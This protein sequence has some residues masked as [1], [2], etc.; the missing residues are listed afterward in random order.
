MSRIPKPRQGRRRSLLTGE[1][2]NSL[3]FS[4][5]RR[6]LRLE[7][8]EDR[9]LL[10]TLWTWDQQAAIDYANSWYDGHNTAR[11]ADY[12]AVGGDCA[13]FVSQCLIAG[14][15]DLSSGIVDGYGSIINCDN[16]HSY[17]IGLAGSPV[18]VQSE[19]RTRDQVETLWFLP[20]DPAIFGRADDSWTHAVIAVTGDMHHYCTCASHSPNVIYS[21]S[22]FFTNYPLLTQC[23]YYDLTDH[24]EPSSTQFA[25]GDYL[26]ATAVVAMRT[27][28]CFGAIKVAALPSGIPPGS[29]VQVLNDAQNGRAYNGHYWWK[30]QYGSAVGWCAGDWFTIQTLTEDRFEP[31]DSFAAAADWG[32]LGD[33]SEDDL[34]IHAPNN[35][36]YYQFTA[37]STGTMNV[38]IDFTHSLGDLDLYFYDSSQT[39]LAKSIGITNHEHLSYSV[40]GGE[41]YYIKVVGYQGATNPLYRLVLSFEDTYHTWD[42]GGTNNLWTTPENWIGDDL[43]IPAESVVFPS[44]AAPRNSINDFPPGTAFQAIIFEGTGYHLQGNAPQL[45]AGIFDRSSGGANNLVDF[46]GITLAGPI[47]LQN[48]RSVGTLVV[49]SDIN[50]GAYTLTV[51]AVG[52]TRLE[53][54]ISG[55]GGLVKTGGDVLTI[56]GANAYTGNTIVQAGRLETIQIHS[57]EPT[58]TVEVQE[59]A[60]LEAEVIHSGA[61]I[62]RAGGKVTLRPVTSSV[63]ASPQSNQASAAADSHLPCSFPDPLEKPESRES[64]VE[65]QVQKTT[66]DPRSTT[67]DSPQ[68][69]IFNP[70]EEEEQGSSD[71]KRGQGVKGQKSRVDVRLQATTPD[72]Q[73]TNGTSQTLPAV[74]DAVFL[75]AAQEQWLANVPWIDLGEPFPQRQKSQISLGVQRALDAVGEDDFFTQASARRIKVLT[76]RMKVAD[77]ETGMIELLSP[78]P[79]TNRQDPRF[80]APPE[81]WQSLPSQ[82]DHHDLICVTGSFFLAGELQEILCRL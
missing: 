39:E 32:I 74:C 38:D 75:H 54:D 5:N 47:T 55:A 8:L 30:V 11:Y 28:P 51:D 66:N 21:I 48:L 69:L 15:L 41:L 12:S 10:T 6:K 27:E 73:P 76:R 29:T 67:N 31:N 3:R 13:N 46:F 25:A 77:S 33:R 56:T 17:L 16:L 49:Q 62:V 23:T 63:T 34:S 60:Q 9:R 20:G 43:P 58:A 78:L 59:N 4:P 68:S 82:V 61:L 7:V 71:E 70:R 52:R 44:G 65:G 72:P 35:N 57:T 2:A 19:V 14:G 40:T 1:G 22:D 64:Q 37:A 26:L 45:S 79:P 50:L 53:G 80:P 42:G 81:V 18:F 24:S 36:D